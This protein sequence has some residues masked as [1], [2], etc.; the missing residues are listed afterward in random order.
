MW[1]FESMNS[2]KANAGKYELIGYV[3]R[4]DEYLHENSNINVRADSTSRSLCVWQEQKLKKHF[5][6]PDR[7]WRSNLTL[8]YL[9]KPIEIEQVPKGHFIVLKKNIPVF[10]RG[11]RSISSWQTVAIIAVLGNMWSPCSNSPITAQSSGPAL[12]WTVQTW[13]IKSHLD[14]HRRIWRDALQTKTGQILSSE[15]ATLM[16]LRQLRTRNCRIWKKNSIRDPYL[17]PRQ[18]AKQG[19]SSRLLELIGHE[20]IKLAFLFFFIA[21]ANANFLDWMDGGRPSTW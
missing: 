7:R 14:P 17:L 1:P 6:V 20:P 4:D 8:K 18:F 19:N 13:K 9:A 2:R 15:M 21:C 3:V 16:D 10:S 12:G 5:K 11:N